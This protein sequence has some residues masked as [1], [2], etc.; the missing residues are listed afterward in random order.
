MASARALSFAFFAVVVAFIGSTLWSQRANKRA[1][2][3]AL[4]ISRDAAPEIEALAETRANLR[5]LET[6]VLRRVGGEQEEQVAEARQQLDRSL[7]RDRAIVTRA[8]EREAIGRLEAAVREFDLSAERAIEQIRLGAKVDATRTV[9]RDLRDLADAADASAASLIELEARR[10]RIAAEGIEI[11]IAAVNSLA[12]RLDAISAV[13]AIAAALLA[14]RT[15]RSAE[16]AH[17]DHRQL[18]ERKAAE[19]EMFAGR[20]AHDIL[21]P[22][23]TVAMAIS[24]AQRDPAS[25]QAKNALVRSGSSLGRVNRIVDGLL[26]FARAGAQ[27]EAGAVAQVGPAVAGLQDELA[28]LVLQESAQLVVEPFEPCAVEC[29]QGVL[30]SL[31]SNLL[32][33]AFKYLGE[34][35]RRVVT[36]RVLP[37]RGLVRFEVEDT[38]P[39]IPPAMVASLFEP[40]VRGPR[41]GKPGIGLGLATVRR[42]VD[43]HGGKVAVKPAPG[44]GSLF[45]FELAAAEVEATVPGSPGDLPAGRPPARSAPSA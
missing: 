5:L 29:S 14:L 16:R 45:W 37:H 7:Q 28:E 25:A 34:S 36:L 23:S 35:Q 40:Y 20:V 42:L 13:L 17:A 1:S 10:A 26:E 15:V 38:G 33:N 19:L 12:F 3:A 4:A 41:T 30:L 43:S 32:R 24:I 21:S 2:D 31:L 44:G 6:R 27:P 11:A 8:D 39:G 18:I 22:L 9:R